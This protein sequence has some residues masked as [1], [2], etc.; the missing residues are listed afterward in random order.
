[1]WT[2]DIEEE[3]TQG[4]MSTYIQKEEAEDGETAGIK[5]NSVLWL[6]QEPLSSQWPA[7]LAGMAEWRL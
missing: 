5:E 4:E 6:Q 3:M 2:P 7:A 1:M